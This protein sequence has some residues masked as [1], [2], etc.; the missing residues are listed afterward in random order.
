MNTALV[1]LR[2]SCSHMRRKCKPSLRH[3]ARMSWT[4]ELTLVALLPRDNIFYVSIITNSP[5][6]ARNFETK[7]NENRTNRMLEKMLAQPNRL[8]VEL[9]LVL[10][11]K[12]R[13]LRQKRNCSIPLIS[14]LPFTLCFYWSKWVF[15]RRTTTWYVFASNGNSE[16][17]RAPDAIRSDEPP[18]STPADALT[19]ELLASKSAM[20]VFD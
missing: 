9:V 10:K 6:N 8:L 1:R 15:C 17:I 3:F 12:S 4:F 5:S 18:R 16:K 14:R 13:S 19:T 20:W 7:M 2:I 11:E